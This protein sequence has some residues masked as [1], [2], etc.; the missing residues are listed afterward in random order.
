M[1]SVLESRELERRGDQVSAKKNDGE[2]QGATTCN[3]RLVDSLH[4]E[5][6]GKRFKGTPRPQAVSY[7]ENVERK[8]NVPGVG[9]VGV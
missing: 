7:N 8:A 9:E 5:S 3:W 1:T 6:E 2:G 4:A